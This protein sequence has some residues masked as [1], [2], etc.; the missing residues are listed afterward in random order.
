MQP[1]QQGLLPLLG[2]FEMAVRIETGRRLNQ[3]DQKDTFR[4]REML[5]RF[6]KIETGRSLDAENL[7]GER[8]PVQ[9]LS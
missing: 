5:G 8:N 3:A 9:I 7:I 1:F 6:P 4:Q 2:A